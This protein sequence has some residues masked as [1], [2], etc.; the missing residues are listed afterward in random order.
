MIRIFR[1]L[2]VILVIM[3]TACVSIEGVKAAVITAPEAPTS[4]PGVP[5]A[6]VAPEAKTLLLQ[7]EDA[8]TGI[9]KNSEPWVVNVKV[10]KMDNSPAPAVPGAP[11]S[12]DVPDVP[13]RTNEATGSGLIVRSD[14]YILTND[15]V[16]DG[17][18]EVTVALSDGRD[19][20]GTV[21]ADYRSDLAV[22]KIN[23]GVPLP[24]A[25]FGDSDAVLP[26]QW[27]IA[28]G[29]PFDLQNT[30]TVGVISAINRH[31][32]IGGEDNGARYYPDLIQTD[33]AINP[34]NSGGPLLNIDGQVIG[35]NVAIESPVEGSSGVGFAIPSRYAQ[36][37]M[38]DLIS[39]GKVVRGYL[40]IGPSD[41][42]P[43]L[44]TEFGVSSGAWVE[45]VDYDSPAGKA[46]IHATDVITS[47]DGQPVTGELSLRQAISSAVPG[48]AVPIEL[49]RDQQPITMTVTIA[50]PPAAQEDLHPPDV[51]I[52]PRKLG[53]SV[54]TLTASDR[55][56]EALGISLQG[57][58]VTAVTTDGPADLAGVTVGDVVV[59]VGRQIITNADDATKALAASD[60]GQTETVVVVR[61]TQGKISELALDLRP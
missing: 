57:A 28:I 56:D 13:G 40:G 29:S 6:P 30:M 24:V 52:E 44:K 16:V 23:A 7:M 5:V 2:F 42:T 60:N 51:K 20:A 50:P 19:F 4:V 38:N 32:E 14:G 8:F 46:G 41:L 48:T 17:A 47:F 35:I 12:P 39:K 59:R 26:G 45:M 49:V 31:Q 3:V 34:G 10:L 1:P 58:Y 36:S 43:A 54:R 37:V 61:S 53:I 11:T 25:P 33:A 21:S 9:A 22:I 15:H 18:S 27:A 55:Q